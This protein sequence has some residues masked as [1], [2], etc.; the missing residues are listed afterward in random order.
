MFTA[1]M[2]YLQMLNFPCAHN[3]GLWPD[4]VAAKPCGIV[5]VFVFI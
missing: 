4:K 2:N 5:L 1:L 3:D